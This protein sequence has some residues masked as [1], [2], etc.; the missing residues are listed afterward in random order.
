MSIRDIV[1]KETIARLES[2]MPPEEVD[3]MLLSIAETI[4]AKG[5]PQES[6]NP[7]ENPTM[8]K[9]K[10]PGSEPQPMN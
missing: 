6:A 4:L 1:S 8:E 5:Q 10:D 7:S 2:K 9:E 3:K